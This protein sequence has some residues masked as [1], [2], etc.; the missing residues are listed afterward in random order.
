MWLLIAM[1]FIMPFEANPYLYLAPNLLGVFPDFTVIK[2]L[3]LLGFCWAMV[4]LCAG[5]RNA[6]LLVSRAAT[7]FLVF[8]FGV[9]FAGVLSG[10]GFLAISRYFAFLIFMPFVVVAVQTPDDLR[11]VLK[12]MTLSLIVVFPYALRQMLRYNERLGVGLYE[13][14]YFATLLVL[15]IPL[16]FV[17]AAQSPDALRRTLWTL[18]GLVLVLELF[19]TSSRGGFLGL[20]VASMV[21]VYRRRGL[22]GA[23]GVVA[24]LLVALIAVPTDLGSRLW[25]I[26]GD[27]SAEVPVSLAAS[28]RAHEALFWAALRMIADNPIFGVGPLNFKALSTLYTGLAQGNIAHNSFLEIA[29]EFGLPVFAVFM[30]LI[31]TTFRTLNAAT[32]L[33]HTDEGWRL[34]GWAEGLRSGL[35]GFVVSA[36]FISAQYEKLFWLA[37]FVTIVVG[38]FAREAAQAEAAE[39][40]EPAFGPDVALAPVPQPQ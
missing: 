31:V 16:A 30:M 14:N 10:S 27:R 11:R 12:A 8:F 9:V 5:D 23:L 34:A 15:V 13:T 22:G 20:L 36:F 21:F 19:L 25:T 17:F 18:G 4:R 1:I 32:R 40:A 2:L 24:V 6:S 39:P 37:V 7:L 38:R 35:L 3:G 28:N 26:I 29:A 33:A